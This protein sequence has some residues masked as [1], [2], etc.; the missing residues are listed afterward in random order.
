MNDTILRILEAKAV[1]VATFG[2]H[3]TD[4]DMA[5]DVYVEMC[6]HIAQ[7][8]SLK[9]K[10]MMETIA[11]MNI[12]VQH[13]KKSGTFSVHCLDGVIEFDPGKEP[14]FKEIYQEPLVLDIQNPQ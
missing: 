5:T 2:L 4:I 13:P 14:L 7:T 9:S 6:Q 8:Y 10:G 11:G 1:F 12:N 3:P